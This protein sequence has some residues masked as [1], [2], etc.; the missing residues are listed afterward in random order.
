MPHLLDATI[1][2][3]IQG[4]TEFL[5]ISSS[6]HLLF[7]HTFL[8]YNVADSLTFDVALHVGTLVALVGY[9]W[10][11]IIQL[12]QVLF[13]PS[14]QTVP[15]QY[16]RRLV[17]LLML[18]VVPAAVLGALFESFFE[19]LRSPIIVI[20]S[21]VIIGGLFLLSE[22]MHR[23]QR[24]LNDLPWHAALGIGVS[25]ALALIPGVSRSGITIVAGMHSGLSREDAARFT[26]LLSIPTVAGV[27]LKKTLDLR[28]TTLTPQELTA[29]GV[30]IA[31]A[32]TVG[33]LVVRFLMRFL[34]NHR[35]DVF[36]YYRFAIAAAATAI[37]LFR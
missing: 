19:S 9:F 20:V 30:G 17:W 27:A 16:S 7:A 36:A 6:G 32:A 3:A 21:L 5:P 10:R 33:Y 28:G 2:G 37:L 12:L 15:R 14:E 4:L 24:G 13:R 18:A 8:N 35:L 29:M 23:K 22:R 25:Q 31:V 34:Q 1:L 11:D 26:F